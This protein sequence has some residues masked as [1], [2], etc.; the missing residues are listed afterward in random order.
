MSFLNRLKELKEYHDCVK[1]L[2]DSG[3][4]AKKSLEKSSGSCGQDFIAFSSILPGELSKHLTNIN[5]KLGQLTPKRQ[6]SSDSLVTL[7]REFQRVLPIYESF[8]DRKKEFSKL[9]ERLG[10]LEVAHQK[11]S[12][13]SDKYTSKLNKDDGTQITLRV[14]S[15]SAKN[16]YE[17]CKTR[18]ADEEEAIKNEEMMYKKKLFKAITDSIAAFAIAKSASCNA[19][20]DISNHIRE[21]AEQIPDY[22]E[23]DVINEIESE[24]HSLNTSHI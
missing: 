17:R 24:I 11:A 3:K 6:E 19:I 12:K 2:E 7:R 13:E 23:A 14:K 18:F 20:I 15:E 21:H 4:S 1:Y 9:Q 22:V 16:E 8:R 10:K 5:S